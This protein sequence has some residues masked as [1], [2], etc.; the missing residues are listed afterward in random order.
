MGGVG[1]QSAASPAMRGNA[2]A[3]RTSLSTTSSIADRI[4]AAEA[5][6]RKLVSVDEREA[7]SN[8]LRTLA[9]EYEEGWLSGSDE[10]D[11]E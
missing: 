10:T 7:L 5:A 11:E 1:P 2:L 8:G 3:L 6:V 9:E 4:R